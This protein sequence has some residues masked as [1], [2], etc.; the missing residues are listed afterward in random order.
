MS[1]E[2]LV[3]MLLAK[4]AQIASTE[5]GN[6]VKDFVVSVPGYFT[7]RQRRALMDAAKIANINLLR[8]M[9]EHAA[10]ALGYGIFRTAE[11][12]EADP[13]KIVFVDIG[14]SATSVIV[15]SFL[16]SEAKVLSVASDPSLGGRAVDTLLVEHFSNQFL[17]QYKVDPRTRPRPLLR[18]R[19]ECEK[20]KKVLS[21]IPESPLNIECL[22]DDIDV[23]GFMK[24]EDLEALITPLC[25]SLET[26]CRRALESAGLTAADIHSVEI[27]G[28]S[29]RIPAFKQA[30]ETVFGGNLRTTL[31]ADECIARGCAMM[32][33]IL[34]PAF[35]V[36][37]YKLVDVYPFEVS[38]L[39]ELRMG[40]SE[41][42]T[43]MPPMHALPATKAL[44]FPNQ[45]PFSLTMKYLDTQG[46]IDFGDFHVE[47][48]ADA[49]DAKVRVKIRLSSNGV[50]EVATAQLLQEVEVEEII[51][52][53]DV[54]KKAP[55]TESKDVEMKDQLVDG[56][57]TSK[58]DAS[59]STEPVAPGNNEVLDGGEN[60]N[61]GVVPME[62]EVETP[63]TRKV[64][65]LKTSDLIVKQGLIGVGLGS[66]ALADAIEQESKM[67]AQ[68]LYLREKADARNALEAY[69]YEIRSRLDEYGG[70]LREF[71]EEKVCSNFKLLLDKTEEWIYD[72][73]GER[74]GK[75]VL[76]SKREE[77]AAVAAPILSRKYESDNR[78]VQIKN[79][80]E[81]SA[82]YKQVNIQTE[83]YDHLTD[84]ERE[85]IL[86]KCEE[87]DRWLVKE[88]EAQAVL[89][90]ASDPTLTLARITEALT[91]LHAVCR[92]IY[93][94]PKPK[95]PVPEVA[96]EAPMDT[97][98]GNAEGASASAT[99]GEEKSAA[100]DMQSNSHPEPTPQAAD[101][102][103]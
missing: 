62:A 85:S 9:N 39:K 42:I 79:L 59:A 97:T 90:K 69:V 68:D 35:K 70:D 93:S 87:T 44:S 92:P 77:L 74:A 30:I 45:G 28:G 83:L 16:R 12:P 82:M 75:S 55:S 29:S 33:A 103:M 6:A 32:G 15:G 54:S 64:K 91:S 88:R 25:K 72:E 78:E 58:D 26:L 27:V 84:A 3:G 31:N 50:A 23:K 36:R 1:Y 89:P 4:L 7:D 17:E 61:N 47:E 67:Q 49:P 5:N 2:A 86:K 11:L 52:T 13:I 43:L 34:S 102:E 53:E 63:K 48:I 81:A 65:K 100:K 46:H 20:L 66:K 38:V 57:S 51:P 56:P 80:E 18:M 94:K 101:M 40:G 95:P 96:Q 10:I 76:Q 73:E 37:E 21:S 60:E 98:S 19:A 71:C 14:Q 22:M 99:S 24:R 8:L 41:L